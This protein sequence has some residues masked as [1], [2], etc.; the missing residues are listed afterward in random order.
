MC[1]MSNTFSMSLKQGGVPTEDPC[2]VGFL[3]PAGLGEDEQGRRRGR[4]RPQ[5]WCLRIFFQQGPDGPLP[6][7]PLYAGTSGNQ[8]HN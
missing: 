6:R 3:R 2:G 8:L 1:P 5:R 7:P 4:S